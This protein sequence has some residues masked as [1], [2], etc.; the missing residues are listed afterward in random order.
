MK[1]Y[2]KLV[3]GTKVE[4]EDGASLGSITSIQPDETTAVEI[5][6]KFT[7]ENVSHVEFYHSDQMNG[8]YDDV[9]LSGA[10]SR[11]TNEDGTVTV[12]V[13]LRQKTELELAVEELQSSQED[14]NQV[15]DTLLS[16]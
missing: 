2:I 13:S 12:M 5:S 11:T 14:Q 16:K 9:K 8:S 7:D 6:V 15:L 3:D 4:I 1:D 10:P